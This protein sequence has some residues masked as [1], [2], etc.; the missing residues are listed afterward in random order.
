[1]NLIQPPYQI[2]GIAESYWSLVAH[3]ERY[4]LDAPLL[5]NNETVD[6]VIR[7]NVLGNRS[8][9]C[10]QNINGIN[11]DDD[12][13]DV[14]ECVFDIYGNPRP[15]MTVGTATQVGFYDPIEQKSAFIE[16]YG[17]QGTI[18]TYTYASGVKTSIDS[19]ND[20]S[21]GN[22]KLKNYDDAGNT[23]KQVHIK[24]ARGVN[25][26]SDII[27]VELTGI[28]R[29]FMNQSFFNNPVSPF[30]VLNVSSANEQQIH[31]LMNIELMPIV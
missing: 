7:N 4:N 28:Y 26:G 19:Y 2:N 3:S 1:M 6:A 13:A 22:R 14:W 16:F 8:V 17:S 29:T 18:T 10:F 5:T 20:K 23:V 31:N 9:I 11:T 27:E 21:V 12:K 15:Y 25:A 24:F 30:V